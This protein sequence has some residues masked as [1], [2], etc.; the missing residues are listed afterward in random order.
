M[1]LLCPLML[2]QELGAPRL[3]V[4]E[5]R[6]PEQ[7]REVRKRVNVLSAYLLLQFPIAN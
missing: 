2:P 7:G 4:W 6:L 1:A 3:Q 5:A